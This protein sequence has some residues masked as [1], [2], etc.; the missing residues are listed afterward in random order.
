[1]S[2]YSFDPT[3]FSRIQK[4]HELFGMILGQHWTSNMTSFKKSKIWHYFSLV[5]NIFN[6]AWKIFVGKK[7][8][9]INITLNR[10]ILAWLN[11]EFFSKKIKNTKISQKSIKRAHFHIHIRCT[12]IFFIIAPNQ[13]MQFFNKGGIIYFFDG[14]HEKKC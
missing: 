3:Y 11:W 9:N 10:N 5:M 8:S 4:F 14:R 7:N 13:K 1:M 12:L 6:D 2:K